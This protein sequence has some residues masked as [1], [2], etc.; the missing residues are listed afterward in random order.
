MQS[1]PSLELG[2]RQQLVLTPQLQQ[3]IRLLNCSSQELEQE[4]AQALEENPM[5]ERLETPDETAVQA[6]Q[7]ERWW[8]Q[9]A[10]RV[11]SDDIPESGRGQNFE[12]FLLQ[13]LHATRATE[14]DRALVAALVSALDEHGYL[15]GALEE[16]AAALPADWEVDPDEL[17]AALRLLQSFDPPGV[18][19]RG[20]AECLAL[21]LGRL[22]D[23]GAEDAA[24][25]DCARRMTAHLD[26]LAAGKF[27]RLCD[28][29]GCDR[30]RLDRAH[31]MILR[32]EPR[33]GRA[34]DSGSIHY[35][36]PDV[37]LHRARGRWQASLNP[38]LAPRLRVNRVYADCLA[39]TDEAGALQEQVRQARTLIRSL[40][41]RQQTILRVAQA[42]AERQHEFLENGP[43]ALRPLV[44]RDIAE[45]LGLH[46]STISR[47]TRQK[48]AQTPWGIYEM[49]Q[50]FGTAVQTRDG[51]DTSA[52]AVRDLMKAILV[53]EPAGRPL[54]DSRIAELLAER[55]VSIARRTVAKYREAMGV[56]TASLRKAR[57][58]LA[59]ACAIQEK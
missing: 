29:L 37:L 46:E 21:Q 36:V 1:R 14:R 7:L 4:L 53:D 25:L 35:I 41:Q 26:L 39:Q 43:R 12:E 48:Y 55:G 57:A 45:E 2:Q 42:L 49:K 8:S 56:P 16:L 52:L 3:A 24:A 33:P 31:A 6:E 44:L 50:F 11:G 54:S 9:P 47:A 51:E 38:A 27:S 32:L 18:G 20:L 13:Q 10:A 28:L 19:A 40:G 59:G 15:D 23:D 5:L 58:G 17:A 34:W 30:A 22:A